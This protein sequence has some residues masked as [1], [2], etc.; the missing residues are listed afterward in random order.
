[1]TEKFLYKDP[2]NETEFYAMSNFIYEELKN[3]LNV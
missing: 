3:T 2:I 1:M